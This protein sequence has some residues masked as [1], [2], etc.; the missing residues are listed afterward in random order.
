MGYYGT[1]TWMVLIMFAIEFL[2]IC[3]T[4]AEYY[5]DTGLCYKAYFLPF[6]KYKSTIRHS[7]QQTLVYIPM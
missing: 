4:T 6:V 7:T 5:M 2:R 1:Y 3:K